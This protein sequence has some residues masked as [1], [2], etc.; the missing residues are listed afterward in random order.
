MMLAIT[1][2][3]KTRETLFTWMGFKFAA[4]SRKLDLRVEGCRRLF[5]RCGCHKAPEE[6][7]T[8]GT[9]RWTTYAEPLIPRRTFKCFGANPISIHANTP[10]A[11]SPSIIARLLPPHSASSR[12]TISTPTPIRAYRIR[13]ATENGDA[14]YVGDGN[15]TCL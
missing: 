14:A 3:P 13:S 2:M 12:A 7:T 5:R 11:V 15:V 6:I 1:T 10:T 9:N 4:A 8:I